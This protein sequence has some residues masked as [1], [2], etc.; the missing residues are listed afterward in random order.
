[1][2]TRS[3][4][5]AALGCIVSFGVVSAGVVL[6][7]DEFPPGQ[8]SLG[9]L[10]F[11]QQ[12]K[13]DRDSIALPGASQNFV[14]LTPAQ[15]ASANGG[16]VTLKVNDYCRTFG[17]LTLSGA[18]RAQLKSS[19]TNPATGETFKA[20]FAESALAD[21]FKLSIALLSGFGL[22]ALTMLGHS[23]D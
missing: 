11:G 9:K 22:M 2:S 4:V 8:L 18:S 15:V 10:R 14:S 20:T 6:A 16:K 7:T 1:M 17:P 5:Y 21:R 19:F 12:A 13:P 3:I 23:H